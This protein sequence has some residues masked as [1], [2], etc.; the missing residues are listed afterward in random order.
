MSEDNDIVLEDEVDYSYTDIIENQ[1]SV[2]STMSE[3][4]DGTYDML[5]EDKVKALS[6]AMKIIHKAQRAI[7]SIV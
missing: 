5:A 2:I 6:L 1:L 3:L 4:E 7:L